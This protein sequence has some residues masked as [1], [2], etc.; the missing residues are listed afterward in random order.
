M[1]LRTATKDENVSRTRT[2]DLI[3]ARDR[4]RVPLIEDSPG[5]ICPK[6]TLSREFDASI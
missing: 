5:G 2:I 4:G 6:L 1:L 3:A